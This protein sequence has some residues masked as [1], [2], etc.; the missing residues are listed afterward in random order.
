QLALHDTL[1]RLPNRVL[2]EDR[3]EQAISKA[4]R[5]RTSFALLFMDLAGGGAAGGMGA[6]LYAF[7]GAQLRRGIEIVT[8]ALHLEACLA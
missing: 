1:T 2:L 3:L 8:D 6:A 5:E 4:N 7:C